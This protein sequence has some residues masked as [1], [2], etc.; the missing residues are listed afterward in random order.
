MARKVSDIEFKK[1]IKEITF[2]CMDEII[3]EH[4]KILTETSKKTVKN[5]D[6]PKK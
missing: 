6:K 1:L 4:S 2:K 3:A 5:S